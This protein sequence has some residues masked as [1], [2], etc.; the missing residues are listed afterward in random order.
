MR[1]QSA[2]DYPIR[3][4]ELGRLELISV[5]TSSIVQL[6]DRSELQ[7]S[8][9]GLAVQRAISHEDAGNVYFE[10]YSIFNR[11]LPSI[12]ETLDDSEGQLIMKTHNKDPRISV[13]SIYVIAVSGAA[14]VLI[15]NG[16]K[17]TAQSRIKD[18]RQYRRPKPYPALQE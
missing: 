17:T 1:L 10:S 14:S 9:R 6:G 5:A 12:P 3:I 8:I 16:M 2:P 13:G 15:G 11:P 7:S 4:S 18:I